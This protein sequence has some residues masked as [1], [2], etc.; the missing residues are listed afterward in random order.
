[1]AVVWV[2]EKIHYFLY[3]GHFILQTDQKPL[4]SIFKKHIIAI[5]SRIQR[6]AI[7]NCQQKFTLQ[8]IFGK[9]N[10]IADALSRVTLQ[11]IPDSSLE[12]PILVVNMLPNSFIKEEERDILRKETELDLE[13]PA[14]KNS[15]LMLK[16]EVCR[17]SG[18]LLKLLKKILIPVTLKSSILK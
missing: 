13:L 1:M 3:V 10:K 12:T 6:I 16:G 14:S 15:F 7:R 17:K 8:W 9:Q 2:F 5:S 4:V 18:T 11:E